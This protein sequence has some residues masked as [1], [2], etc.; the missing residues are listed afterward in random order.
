MFWGIIGSS[1]LR[2]CSTACMWVTEPPPLLPEGRVP[3][4]N[5]SLKNLAKTGRL[6]NVMASKDGVIKA[7]LCAV[8]QRRR[9]LSSETMD[10]AI[11][12]VA[13]PCCVT[14][15]QHSTSLI[16]SHQHF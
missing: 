15:Y 1:E 13:V 5:Y 9:S 4:W 10:I 7:V 14:M 6:W 8:S 12:A 2:N 16:P 11:Q 3:G